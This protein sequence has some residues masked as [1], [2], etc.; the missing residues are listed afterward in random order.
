MYPNGTRATLLTNDPILSLSVSPSGWLAAYV[1]NPDQEN[2]DYN[3]PFGYTLKFITLYDNRIYTIASLDPPGI[4][5][6]SPA[7]V[8]DSAF[9]S[10]NAYSHNALAWSPDSSILAFTSA[11]EAPTDRPASSNIY[12]YRPASNSISRFTDVQ[13]P[14]G[15]GYPYQ[16]DWSPYGRRLFFEVAYSFGGGSDTYFAG[17]W[18]N[19]L[20]GSSIQ[21]ASEE[22]STGERV[23]AWTGYN[24]ILIASANDSCG[25]QNLRNVNLSTGEAT[26]LWPKC[27]QTAVYDRQRNLLL[28]SVT[29]NQIEVTEENT[30]GLYLVSIAQPQPRAISD[31]GFERVLTGQ[32]AGPNSAA[33]YGFNS[34]EGL[35]T[36]QRTGEINPLFTG[37]PFDGSTGAA[38]SPLLQ[39]TT[40]DWLWRGDGLYLCR[41]GYLPQQVIATR[42][43]NLTTS[44]SV[45]GLFFYLAPDQ[46]AVRLFGIH[47]RDWQPFIVDPRILDPKGIDFTG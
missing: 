5:A 38:L 3:Q 46:E 47:M 35:F 10:I 36:I 20:D 21:V 11:H 39:L 44:P 26:S 17:A 1:T 27:Y 15:P 25:I 29:F 41:P 42:P 30:P 16:L 28:V 4:S 19:G 8:L 9:Q 18:I 45:P 24:N 34:G 13:L 7:G 43:D 37:A 12:F 33:W 22:N 31:H 23:L 40:G 32:S 14:Q 6:D 2:I